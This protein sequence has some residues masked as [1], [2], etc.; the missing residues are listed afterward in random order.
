MLSKFAGL[1]QNRIFQLFVVLLSITFYF[2]F[3]FGKFDLFPSDEDVYFQTGLLFK[4]PYLEFGNLLYP[5]G[6]YILSFFISNTINLAY[7]YFFLLSITMFLALLWY[8]KKYSGS[9]WASFFIAACFLF[10]DFQ[11]SLQPRITILNL[12]FGLFFLGLIANKRPLYA[13]WGIISVGLLL[14]NYV[15]RPEFYWF[16]LIATIIFIFQ[17]TKSKEII[18][19][20]KIIVVGAF[21]LFVAFF[22]FIGGGINEP[23]KLKVAFIQHFFDNY[24]VW[25]GKSFDYD[26]EFIVFD[27]IYGKVNADIELITA[28]PSFFFKHVLFNFKNYFLA[29]LKIFKSCFYDVFVIFFHDKT[30]YVFTIFCFLLIIGIDFKQSLQN[31][32]NISKAYFPKFPYLALFMLPTFVAVLLVFPRYHYTILH[33]PFY[34][35]LLVF[36]FVSLKFRTP[37]LKTI[38]L[39]LFIACYF[40][41]VIAHY[42]SRIKL[43]SHV[44][45]YK[46]MAQMANGKRLSLLSNDYFGFNYYK[47]NYTKTS[48]KVS[49][50]DLVK[51]VNTQKY[52]L[53]TFYQMDLEVEDNRKFVLEGYKSTNYIRIKKFEGIKRYIFVKPE[54]EA[55][56]NTQ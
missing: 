9:F 33:L 26:E 45:F 2:F 41:G 14:C 30:K 32:W 23:G 5:M 16:F 29:T 46:Y 28:N 25:T 7:S 40:L 43:P 55:K 49:K 52:D 18:L 34:F 47:T 20:K 37:K 31:F 22:Y 4:L 24:Q 42:P 44:G 19:N 38:A 50:T 35:L 51:L 17:T 15:S 13:N 6:I 21:G 27:K 36:L 10:S 8:L 11:V 12:I 3:S 54:L 39:F 48:W 56:F 53:I 1:S